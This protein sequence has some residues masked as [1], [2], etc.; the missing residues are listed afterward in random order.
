MAPLVL[1]AADLDAVCRWAAS[2]GSVATDGAAR[3]EQR[4]ISHL[5]AR[6]YCCPSLPLHLL[7][8]RAQPRA[9]LPPEASVAWSL[10][11]G[12]T[13]R[14]ESHELGRGSQ[15]AADAF[16]ARR[17]RERREGREARR[18]MEARRGEQRRAEESG[19]KSIKK[20]TSERNCNTQTNQVNR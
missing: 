20:C 14:A 10:I 7:P 19:Q 18:R 13:L 9:R 5:R 8:S 2:A 12:A 3:S 17:K 15:L 16:A 1:L 4:A 11:L 6:N